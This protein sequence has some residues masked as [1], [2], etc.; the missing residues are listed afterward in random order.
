MKKLLENVPQY[1]EPHINDCFHNAYAAV[2]QYMGFNPNVILAD[3]LSFMY[4]RKLDYIGVDYF[5]RSNTSV[6]FSEEE[7]NTSMEFVYCPMT[8]CFSPHSEM[9][10][11]VRY[12]DRININM[13]VSDDS[14]IAY[15]RTKELIDNG[16]PAIAAVDLYYMQ[17]HRAYGKEHGL[18]C[19]VI[20]GYNEE[21]GYFELFDRYKLS[22][23]D[24]SGRLPIREVNLGRVSDNP[25]PTGDMHKRP[26]RNFWIELY[27]DPD[28]KITEEKQLNILNESCMRMTGQK[29]VLGHRCGL[30]ALDSFIQALLEKKEEEMNPDRVYW[31][32]TYLNGSL[33]NVARNRKRFMVLLGEIKDLLPADLT[34]DL[35]SWSDE[36]SNHWDICANIALKLGIRKSLALTDDLVKQLGVIRE[37]E[38]RLVE[39]LNGFLQSRGFSK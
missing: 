16:I 8:A 2:L 35:L 31:Y 29:E 39:K 10:G 25:L 12:K 7:M 14:D 17:Y 6:E 18:H 20:T 13:Y 1:F 24:F 32:R 37:T 4:D 21:E 34:P 27:A 11:K 38:N 19:V 36:A 30:G 22:S 15:A 3:Y 26:I 5:L 33:K 23:S 28:F 9:I